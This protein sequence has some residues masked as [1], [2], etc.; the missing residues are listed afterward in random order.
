MSNNNPNPLL[1]DP[2]TGVCEM[3]QTAPT[4]TAGIIPTTKPVKVIYYTDPI[5]SS[6][7]GIEPQLRKLKLEYG[8]YIDIDY[9]MGGLLP[10]WSY[11]SGGISKPADVAHHWDEVSLYYEMPIDGDVWLEDPLDSSYPACI[12]LKAAQMQDK[13]KAVTF[14]RILREKLFLDK[15]NIAK[16]PAIAQAATEAGLDAQQLKTDFEGPAKKLF[17]EDLAYGRTLGV[18]GFPTLFF[19][20]GKDIKNTVY[21]SKPY[22]QFEQALLAVYP[23]AKKTA[24]NNTTPLALFNVFPSLTAKEYAVILETGVNDAKTT[25]EKACND[26]LLTK[27][28]IKTGTMYRKK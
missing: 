22:E 6:C 3:P 18:R 8:A 1:C 7:W 28:T 11:N 13:A 15:Q 24:F 23:Q 4:G 14:M 25:L 21:G 19:S 16:W 5:C 27:Q 10:D 12:A 26:G 20:D 9:R 17:E 2:E